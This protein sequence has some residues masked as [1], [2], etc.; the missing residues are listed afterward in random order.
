MGI[1]LST[2]QAY[3]E[4]DEFLKLI[5]EEKRRKVPEELRKLFKEEK[6]DNYTKTINPKIHIKDQELKE[7]T[8][9]IIA[10]LNIQYWC[11]DENEKERLKEV[12]AK[13]EKTYQEYF[14]VD[15][16]P[17]KIF[18]K[19]EYMEA[20]LPNIIEEQSLIKRFINRI[21]NMFVK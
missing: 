19:K 3:S 1:S 5:S 18:K 8:L 6:D 20:S 7:E 13:N 9:A 16:E 15:F 21:K 2:R 10:L 4:V 14:Q 11:E 17:D 12:Y